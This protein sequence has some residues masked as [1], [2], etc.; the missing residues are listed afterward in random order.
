VHQTYVTLAFSSTGIVVFSH[1]GRSAEFSPVLSCAAKKFKEYRFER[2]PN[3][4]LVRE[5]HTSKAGRGFYWKT[6]RENRAI[7]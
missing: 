1:R 3:Y 7:V 5:A 6:D 2:T 4:Q